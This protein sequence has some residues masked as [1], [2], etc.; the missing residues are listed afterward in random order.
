MTACYRRL[1]LPISIAAAC[2]LVL[3]LVLASQPLLAAVVEGIGHASIH[4]GDIDSARA[5]ARQAALRDMALQYD[6]RIS[7][8]DTVENG[9]LTS[10]RLRVT[11]DVRARNVQVVDEF[12]SGQLLRVTLRAEMTAQ[13]SSCGNGAASTLKKRVAITGF[14]LLYPDHARV[15]RLDD[16]GEML[17]QQLQA[18][19]R[20]AGSVQ[21]L[22]ATSLRMYG[23]LLNAPTAQQDDNRLT[24][25]RQLARELGA[26]FVVSGVIRDLDV[27]DPAAWNTSVLG[28]LKR[29]AGAVDQTRRFIADMVIYD[30]FSGAPVYQQRFSARAQ[31]NAGPG[32][33]SGFAS[34]GFEQTDYG[35]AV[36]QVMD[37]MARSVTDALNCQPFMTRISRVDGELVTIE[38]GATSGIAAV[39]NAAGIPQCASL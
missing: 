3:A 24:N 14:P 30:G 17:P 8:S 12:R 19:L 13:Q 33:A 23:D 16:A 2:A 37:D 39:S 34:A 26:Q 32:S 36:A 10:S 21:V 9:V 18:R 15:G 4:N 1:T 29:S 31:W 11:S 25:V 38:S 7:N 5:L 27:A 28:K 20:N 6:A 22:S 35:K